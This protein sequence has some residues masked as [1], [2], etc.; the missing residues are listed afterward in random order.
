MKPDT[1]S[2]IKSDTI[3]NGASLYAASE[4]D[5]TFDEMLD[6]PFHLWGGEPLADW[7]LGVSFTDSICDYC[8]QR[9]RNCDC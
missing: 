3:S 2:D 5:G 4:Y 9:G 7:R 1:N 8:G 6:T